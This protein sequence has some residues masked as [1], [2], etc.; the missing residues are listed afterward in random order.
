MPLE[1]SSNR[2]FPERTEAFS[3][4]AQPLVL[5][6]EKASEGVDSGAGQTWTGLTAPAAHL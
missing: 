4:F 1:S 3:L 6:R 2:P 5:V